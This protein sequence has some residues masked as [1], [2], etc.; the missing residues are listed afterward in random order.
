M[1]SWGIVLRKLLDFLPDSLFRAHQTFSSSVDCIC[2][3][4]ELVSA[5]NVLPRGPSSAPLPSHI[6]PDHASHE[7][8]ST[9]WTSAELVGTEFMQKPLPV[10]EGAESPPTW[11]EVTREWQELEQTQ[12]SETL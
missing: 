2:H 9:A 1:N 8:R 6:L 5:Q 11:A 7:Q 12:G 4:H 3:V 10:G